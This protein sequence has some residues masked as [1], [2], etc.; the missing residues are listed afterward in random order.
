MEDYR[1][2]SLAGVARVSVPF[3]SAIEGWLSLWEFA[4]ICMVAMKLRL[5]C[6]G[7]VSGTAVATGP[8]MRITECKFCRERLSLLTTDRYVYVKKK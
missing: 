8:R 7:C 4:R 6:V 3:G 1:N 5:E 2:F